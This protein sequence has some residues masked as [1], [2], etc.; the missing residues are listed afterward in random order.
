MIFDHFW[1]NSFSGP[2]GGMIFSFS[3]VLVAANMA[4]GLSSLS[5][6]CERPG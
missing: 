1:P 4:A 3:R 2:F 6:F 5:W